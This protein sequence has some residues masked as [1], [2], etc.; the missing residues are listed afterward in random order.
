LGLTIFY[1]IEE[2]I[3]VLKTMFWK[4]TERELKTNTRIPDALEKIEGS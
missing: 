4:T 2:K 1:D 3:N